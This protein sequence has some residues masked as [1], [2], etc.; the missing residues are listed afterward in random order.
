MHMP[1]E[2]G[3]GAHAKEVRSRDLMRLWQ[4]EHVEMRRRS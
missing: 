1:P 3:G 4:M 2:G